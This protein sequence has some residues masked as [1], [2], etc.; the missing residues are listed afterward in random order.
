MRFRS[1]FPAREVAPIRCNADRCAVSVGYQWY[2]AEHL[3]PLFPFGFGLSYT[4]FKLSGL[5]VRPDG[6]NVL[7]S[8]IVTNT[9]KRAGAE[10]AQVYVSDPAAA[11]EPPQQLKAYQRTELRPGQSA[12]VTL[13]LDDAAFSYWSTD[14]GSWQIAPGTYSIRVGDS[15]ADEPLSAQVTR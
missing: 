13:T 3:T 15:S 6:S 9:G 4:S 7:V 12:P 1:F 11:G 8:Y 5:R 10:V 2:D 14:T